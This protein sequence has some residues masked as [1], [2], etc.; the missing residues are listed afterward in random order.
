LSLKSSI[1]NTFYQ[2]ALK[3]KK[4]MARESI[5]GMNL[6]KARTVAVLADIN[7]AG[8]SDILKYVESLKKENKTVF[9]LGYSSDAK[10]PEGLD[11]DIFC[12]KDFNWALVPKGAVVD[13]FLGENYD[14]LLSL[15]KETSPGLDFLAEA[16]AAHIKAS[17]YRA[18]KST[19]FNVMVQ[20]AE[21]DLVKS[22]G[23]LH[24]LL[25]KINS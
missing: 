4:K 24:S 13:K 3:R 6:S 1:Q 19:V 16:C 11:F 17:Y 2:Q 21:N 9:F 15:Y 20:N 25:K 18:D 10:I 12:K 23:Q 8:F 7:A 14:I 5:S 22:I